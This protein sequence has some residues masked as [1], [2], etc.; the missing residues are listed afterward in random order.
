MHGYEIHQYIC[1]LGGL[2]LVWHVK[3]SHLYAMSDK[4]EAE[5]QIAGQQQVQDTRPPRRMFHLTPTGRKSFRDWLRRP[6]AHG[7]DVRLEFMAKLFFVQLEGAESVTRLIKSQQ[8]ECTQWHTNLLSQAQATGGRGS[9]EWLVYRFRI[10]QV[11]A[12]MNWLDLCAKARSELV[13][14]SRSDDA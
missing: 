9:Y 1:S 7:R 11:Q 13:A 6:V 8:L 10:G 2:G 12:M 3:Q 5:G 14:K 4:L